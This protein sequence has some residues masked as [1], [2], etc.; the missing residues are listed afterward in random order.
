VGRLDGK[1]AIVTGSARGQGE[2]E[3]R[4]FA[5]EGACVVGVDLLGDLGQKVADDLGDRAVFC[6]EDVSEEAAW[7][8]IVAAAERVFGRIDVLVNN[9]AE[10]MLESLEETSL[11]HYLR[12][13]AVNQI[14]VFL[15][16][17]AV[18]PVMRGGWGRVHCQRV[19]HRRDDRDERRGCVRLHEVRR[20]WADQGGGAGAR[21]GRHPGKRVGAGLGEYRDARQQQ[22]ER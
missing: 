12:I 14:G 13:V 9:A 5:D 20:P 8:R 11:E 17:R 4:L 2:A 15:G 10:L 18:A 16:M 1:V 19:F 6:C 7:P 22:P 3:A 21:Q